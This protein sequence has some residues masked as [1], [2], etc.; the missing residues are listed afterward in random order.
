MEE[1]IQPQ[2][3]SVPEAV[4]AEIPQLAEQ[5]G[6]E[7]KPQVEPKRTYTQEEWSKRESEKDK[8]IAQTREHLAQL[9][10][11]AELY[12]M[13]RAET[14][15]KARDRREV[16]EGTITISEATQR[17]QARQQQWQ[18]G[19]TVVQ[20]Q[21]VLR[22]MAQQTEQYGRL[23]AAQDFGKEYNL[24]QE[25]ITELL[26][27]KDTRTPGD[28]RAKAA[29]LA[30]ERLQGELKKS[31]GAPPKFDQGLSGGVGESTPEKAL[32]GRYPTMFKK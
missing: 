4:E 10:M 21:A 20:T 17:E 9:A 26:S 13:Q 5:P 7:E 2:V 12:Q 28:M 8:E 22:Q 23:L 25:Q 16:D 29:N 15:A 6:V 11:Q 1:I 30:L 18:Q 14:E 27:D 3:E 19:Q 24:S 31:K 32:K